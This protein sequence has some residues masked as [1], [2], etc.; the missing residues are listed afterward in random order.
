[1][2]I[3]FKDVA[4]LA[5]VSTQTVSRVTNGSDNVAEA[6]RKR[7]NDAIKTLG[8]IPNKGAQ[9]LSRAK[10]RIIGLVSLDISLHGV[11]L[12]AKGVRS[13]AHEMNFATA[14]SVIKNN[15]AE[16]LRLAIRELIAQQVDAVI[17]N[18]PVE[19]NI[20]ENLVEQFSQL[21]IV[22]IDVPEGTHVN[23]ICCDHRAGASAAVL[24]LVEQGRKE[25]VCITGPAES[26]A[27]A[28]R[29][30]EWKNKLNY[31]ALKEVAY[32]EGNWQANSGYKAI[33]EVVVEGKIFDAVLVANDQMALGV[34][35]A[36]AEVGIKVPQVVSIVGFDGIEDSQFFSP[37]LTTIK[38][39]FDELG[40]QAVKLVL[41]SIDK[42]GT[43]SI[44]LP[45]NLLIR[46][47]TT[48]K[49]NGK[50]NKEEVLE[51]LEFIRRLL[52]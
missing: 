21:T 22:F 19:R 51:H 30:D 47:S 16:D 46:S 8:Y 18:V 23:Y 49:S 15:S 20:A 25:F 2:A 41:N 11:A 13:Q 27:S 17:I 34:L 32:Y 1:M 43:T 44:A 48:Q 10:S 12:I 36:L 14:L 35:C 33:K 45:V 37:P 3:T 40:R 5:G 31:F 42:Q 26:T 29:Y 7:V 52:P 38:Q 6:T 24:H 50:Y 9:M 39:D 4:R 28:I